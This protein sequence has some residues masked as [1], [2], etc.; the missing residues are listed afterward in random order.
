MERKLLI[1][2][3]NI[4]YD[5]LFDA[6]EFLKLI[7]EWFRENGYNKNDMK[8]IE[9]TSEKSKF[10]NLEIMPWKEVSDYAT[11]EIYV[12][13]MIK[14]MVE[15]NIKKGE[16]KLKINKGNISIT[17]DAFLATDT[18]HRFGA[19]PVF[20]FF[21]TIFDKFI[22]RDYT[23]KLERQLMDDVKNF[24]TEMKSFLNLQRYSEPA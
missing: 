14:D 8:H 12:R 11:Y 5:G 23:S 20:F 21:R 4:G 16:Q 15:K 7:D 24:H 9:R 1:S 22:N 6:E 18:K 3:L 10:I 19:K 17:I 2:N 13:V